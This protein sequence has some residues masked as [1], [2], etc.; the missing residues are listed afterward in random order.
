MSEAEVLERLREAILNYDMEAAKRAAEET[1]EAKVDPLKA[2]Q[3]ALAPAIKEM[4]ERFHRYEIFLPH[5]VIAADAMEAAV[6]V[7]EAALP[8]D[9]IPKKR[10]MVIGTVEGDVHEIGKNVVAMMLKAAGFEVLDLGVDVKSSSFIDKA[11]ANDAEII[12]MS[13]LM[14]TTMPYMG[15]VIDDLR[16]TNMRDRFKVVVGGGPVTEEYAKKIGS[17]GYGRDGH[18]AVQVVKG[19]LGI[20]EGQK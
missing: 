4:G 6:R 12:A 11:Q 17:D 10:T 16:T 19:V 9:K 7:L 1:L 5:V 13:S 8:K 2:I 3:E 15:E 18:G 20:K 14:T